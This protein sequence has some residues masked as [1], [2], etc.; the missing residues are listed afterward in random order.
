MSLQLSLIVTEY[1]VDD[2]IFTTKMCINL[3]NCNC[4]YKIY[5]LLKKHFNFMSK[6][7]VLLINLNSEKYLINMKEY[8]TL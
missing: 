8:Y 6:A 4:K 1:T 2:I 3:L 5:I 7:F